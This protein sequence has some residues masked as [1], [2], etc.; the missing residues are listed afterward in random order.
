MV[1]IQG[2]L[3]LERYFDDLPDGY[4]ITY[5]ETGFSND[6][7]SYNWV[8]HFI[9]YSA[10][11]QKGVSRLL[12]FDGFDS[13]C[14][15]EFLENLEDNY[16]IPYRL[17]SHTSHFLQPLDVGP[18]QPYKHW[19]AEA[20]DAA[21]RTGCTSFNKVE[22][23]AAI[24]SIRHFTFKRR[25]IMKGWKETGL[26]PPNLAIIQ[27]NIERESP[28]I[29]TQPATQP[30]RQSVRQSVSQPELDSD[31]DSEIDIELQKRVL[32]FNKEA[33][34]LAG[35]LDDRLYD[36]LYDQLYAELDDQLDNQLESSPIQTPTCIRTLKHYHTKLLKRIDHPDLKRVQKGAENL[37]VAGDQAVA[38]LTTMTSIA[39][40]R[41][42]RQLRTN[43]VLRTEMGVIYS[44]QARKM[45]N[46]RVWGEVAIIIRK[47]CQ[48]KQPPVTAQK[49][50]AVAYKPVHKQLELVWASM[51]TSGYLPAED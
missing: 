6:E 21:T 11:Y 20:V 35:Q 25:T 33:Q 23:L 18:F 39:Q 2:A 7:I 3:F 16:I 31:L 8:K 38:E 41:R 10:N 28:T 14:T 51:R 43:K 26:F 13:H 1:I 47:N 17:P 42:K 44:H 29:V 30:T 9:K 4:L 40:T 24:E 34:R 36:Q 5:S 19:H 15:Q 32:E 48:M 49:R 46:N 12:L 50:H 45:V 27:S 37:A 22:F